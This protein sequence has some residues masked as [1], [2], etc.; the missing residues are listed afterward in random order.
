MK[1]GQIV[2]KSLLDTKN[3]VLGSTHFSMSIHE[4]LRNQRNGCKIC[5]LQLFFTTI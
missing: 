1:C 3:V 4:S 5:Q 2:S